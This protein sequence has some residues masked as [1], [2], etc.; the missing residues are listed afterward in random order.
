[1]KKL[2]FSKVKI[3]LILSLCLTIFL[4]GFSLYSCVDQMDYNDTPVKFRQIIHAGGELWGYDSQGTYRSFLGSNSLEGLE[5]CAQGGFGAVELDLSFT[6]DDRLV[7]I[8]DWSREYIDTLKE[9]E[10]PAWEE[11]KS[12]K[13]FWNYTPIDIDDAAEFLAGH[14]GMYI[15]TDIK[16]RFAEAV[17][18]VKNAFGEK[19]LCDRVVIQ[20]YS[21][22]EYNIAAGQGFENIIY[23]LY[24]LDWNTKTDVKSLVK[25]A[26]YH[27]L[28]GFTFSYELCDI[29][30]YVDGMKKAGIPLYV[31]TVNDPAE[32]QKYLDMGIYGIYTD[33]LAAER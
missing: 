18:A 14:P 23:S 1:M 21:E 28:I 9:G 27:K 12:S 19:R 26:R 2:Y 8:H 6:S 17:S 20:V 10:A 3:I 7:C 4:S 33:A 24:K 13:I 16:E 5:Q 31:H 30:G 32:A 22:E 15:V 25:F 11:F 29:P